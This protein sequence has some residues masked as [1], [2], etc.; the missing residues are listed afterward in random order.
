MGAW[1]LEKH[2]RVTCSQ[3]HDGA[4][5]KDNTRESSVGLQLACHFPSKV[6]DEASARG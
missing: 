5:D 6:Q 3:E 1:L 2:H 4:W